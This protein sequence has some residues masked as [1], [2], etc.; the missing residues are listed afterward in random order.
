MCRRGGSERCADAALINIGG[1]QGTCPNGQLH[2]HCTDIRLLEEETFSELDYLQKYI[3]FMSNCGLEL[4]PV[5]V[6]GGVRVR[7]WGR[8]GERAGVSD[9]HSMSCPGLSPAARACLLT[10]E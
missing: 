4:T 2:F 5:L 9:G 8:G 3:E 7:R 6:R 1:V 10:V